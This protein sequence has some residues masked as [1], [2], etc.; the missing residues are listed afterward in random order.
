MQLSEQENIR[1]QSKA[2]LE[3]LGINPYP[4][5]LFEVNATARDINENYERLKG[6]YQNISIAGRIMSR[7]IMG[8]AAFTELQDETGR[9]QIYLRRDDLC[10]G[11]DK[12]LYNTVFKKLLDI[13]DIIGIQG[14][15]FTTQTGEISVH[16]TS[17]KVLAKSL[18]PLP[19]V[20]ETVDE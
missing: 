14:Y 6:D 2:E 9:I 8:S 15:G 16:V 17:L 1:R 18:R 4:A 19:I 3:K 11:E 7:R 12:T 5:E 13:G 20:K 10:T